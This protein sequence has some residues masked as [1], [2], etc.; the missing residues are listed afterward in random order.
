MSKDKPV[1]LQVNVVANWGSTGRIAEEIGQL[2]VE[3]GWRSVIA[4]GRRANPSKNELIRIGNDFDNNL[5][6]IQTRLFDNHGLAS[7]TATKKFINQIEKI[8]PDIIHLHN[9]HGYYLNYRL[10]FDYLSKK[11]VPIVWTLHD[12][13]AMTGHCAYFD[14]AGC[15]R[16]KTGCHPPCPWKRHF[17]ESLLLDS[18]RRN[19]IL[20]KE[21]FNSVKKMTLVTV[22]KWLGS[23]VK[24][25]YLGGYPIKVIYNGVNHDVLY[26]RKDLSRL[27][28]K[29][30]LKEKF[31]TVGVAMGF[32]ERKGYNDYLRLRKELP[33]DVMIVMIGLEKN[34]TNSIP[35]GIIGIERTES[36]DELAQ[37][38]SLADVVLNFGYEETFGLTTAEGFAC[39]TPVIAYN[40]T[41]SPELLT[42]ETG[43]V[44]EAGNINQIVQAINTIKKNGKAY[45]SEACRKR[46]LEEFDKNKNYLKYIDLY[47]QLIGR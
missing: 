46:A 38:Y 33:Q 31:I 19:W 41:A 8:N 9:I 43:I 30:G 24:E 25:S 1:L 18:S 3:N 22:S 44:V 39:G 34:K 47:N 10:F 4:Y 37:W 5:H 12:C 2:A 40:K 23:I 32:G 11:D 7:R 36:Q 21:S 28:E 45:Y 42:P 27:R 16:W 26:P 35:E 29:Y 14:Y 13:W 17:P 15:E 20:K 6:A